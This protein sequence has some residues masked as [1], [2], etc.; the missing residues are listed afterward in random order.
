MIK[1]KVGVKIYPMPESLVFSCAKIL[2]LI[3][4]LF[5]AAERSIPTYFLKFK[6]ILVEFTNFINP[7]K[8]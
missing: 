1:P 6:I 8:T 7:P 4:L 3:S 2:F 5:V